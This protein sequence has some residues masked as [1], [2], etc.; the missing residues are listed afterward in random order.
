MDLHFTHLIIHLFQF[1][2][3]VYLY[4]DKYTSYIQISEPLEFQNSQVKHV[5]L[6]GE[7]DDTTIV[8]Q[9]GA[10]CPSSPKIGASLPFVS[11]NLTL[12][13]LLKTTKISTPTGQ[14]IIYFMHMHNTAGTTMCH[15]ATAQTKNKNF[16]MNKVGSRNCNV[17]LQLTF[18]DIGAHFG[19]ATPCCGDTIEQQKNYARTSKDDFVANEMFLPSELDH[20][21]Y[22]G[23]SNF[24]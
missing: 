1:G 23:R 7:S 10:D 3:I 20:D 5:I 18:Q 17:F 8:E 24:I 22:R 16:K 2:I 9:N 21:N 15:I 12:N 6:H 14:K 4:D 19:H 11:S 13:N